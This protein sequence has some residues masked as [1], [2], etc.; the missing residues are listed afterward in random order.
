MKRLLAKAERARIEQAVAALERGTRAE[1][2]VV[3]ARAA[4]DYWDVSLIW[5]TLVAL[6][7]PAIAWLAAPTLPAIWL[8]DLQL[9][10]F[11][12]VLT[13]TRVP[14]VARALVPA[15]TQRNYA[16]QMA[17]AQFFAQGLH[18]TSER[19]GILLFVA[20]QEHYVEVLADT[21]IAAR[22][23]ASEWTQLIAD[24]TRALR[25]NDVTRGFVAAVEQCAAVAARDFARSDGR[26]RNELPNRVIELP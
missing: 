21:G 16:A 5:A 9:V 14:A 13:L 26:A 23:P 1:L 12:A 10:L 15:A 20:E 4:D 6:V 25:A 7:T 19:T 8:Y 22:V 24:L 11:L 18:H 2:V 3:C 17:R